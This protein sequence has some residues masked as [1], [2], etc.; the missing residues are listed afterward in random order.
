VDDAEADQ[1]EEV[2]DVERVPAVGEEALLLQAFGSSATM[3][4]IS[5]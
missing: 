3:R 4:W 2:A 1:G 5:S